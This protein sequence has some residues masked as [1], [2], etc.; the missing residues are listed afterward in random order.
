MNILEA[1]VS[2]LEV[3]AKGTIQD[4]TQR[5][6]CNK[7]ISEMWENLQ[8]IKQ[9]ENGQG[10][11][12]KYLKKYWS[13]F[14]PYLMKTINTQIQDAQQFPNTRHIKSKQNYSKAYCLKPVRRKILK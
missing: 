9:L 12:E 13:L 5:K 7:H 6:D 1:K 2:D 14:S 11:Q 4:E 3:T 8:V 10:G